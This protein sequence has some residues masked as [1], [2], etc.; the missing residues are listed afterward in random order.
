MGIITD[1]FD[2]I[3][4]MKVTAGLQTQPSSVSKSIFPLL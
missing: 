4:Y 2:F 3:F 1:D